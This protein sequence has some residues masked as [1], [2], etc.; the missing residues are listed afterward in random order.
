[1]TDKKLLKQLDDLPKSPGVYLFSDKKRKLLYVGKAKNLRARVRSYFQQSPKGPRIRTMVQRIEHLE[2]VVT[3]TESEALLLENSFIKNNKP[4]FNV[5]LRDDKTYPYIKITREPFPRVILTRRK[6]DDGG[7]YFGPFP[8][9]RAARG[10]IKL[11]HQHFKV[12]SC[13]LSLGVKRYRP[14]LQFHIKRC[15]APCDFLVDE[16]VYARGLERA[17]LFLEGKRDDLVREISAEMTDSAQKLEYER[18]AYFRDLLGLV[19]AVQR[20]QNVASLQ[21]QRLDVVATRSDGWNGTILIMAIRRGS[22]V[23]TNHFKVEWEEDPA[24][25]LG[26]W[27]THYYLN[28]EDPPSELV[29]ASEQ[30]LALLGD[31]FH[32]AREQKLK[33]TVPERG[34]KSRLLEMALANIDIYLEMQQAEKDAHP[35]VIQLADALDL[36]ALPLSMECF[37][38]SNTQGSL[39]VASMAYFK[40]GKPDKKNYRKFN[41]KTVEGSNDFASIEEVVT[42]RYR[43]L[44]DE[45]TPLPDLIVIDGGLGQLHAAHNALTSLGLGDHPL[46]SLAKREEW[47]HRVGTSEPVIIPHHEPALRMLQHLRDETH[48]FGVTFHRKKRG[49]HMLVSALDEIPGVGP[50]RVRKLL[51]HFGSVKRIK[52][53]SPDQIA[54]VV[55]KKIAAAVVANLDAL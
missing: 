33:I 14:C 6:R 28:H 3:E 22:I 4:Y 35:G 24:G 45:A 13:D 31:A 11:I 12:R 55:G 10:S 20:G 16:T 44:L 37:D 15:D 25:D 19:A 23:R 47:I 52:E 30:G 46:I 2:I 7:R 5:L 17:A 32:K 42:R 50:V 54:G 36:N 51:H 34:A 1:M 48:R 18:A 43:R 29:V 49:K 21:Y 53:A 40:N 27:L 8:S 39:S 38:I 9:T 41:I 26:N